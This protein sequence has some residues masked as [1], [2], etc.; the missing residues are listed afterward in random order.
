MKQQSEW[1][2]LDSQVDLLQ[3]WIIFFLFLPNISWKWLINPIYDKS[4]LRHTGFYFHR[5]TCIWKCQEGTNDHMSMVVLQQFNN[6]KK[7]LKTGDQTRECLLLKRGNVKK[8]GPFYV[9]WLVFP[10]NKHSLIWSLSQVQN[11][12]PPLTAAPGGLENLR[13]V[14][15]ICSVFLLHLSSECCSLCIRSMFAVHVFVWHS[16]NALGRCSVFAIVD[17]SGLMLE[18]QGKPIRSSIGRVAIAI[19]AC[20]SEWALS[21]LIRKAEAK[22]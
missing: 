22:Y 12:A 1:E 4:E 19:S 6:K 2:W 17:W 14:D 15:S 3:I 20:H 9:P 18:Y 10:L 7:S 13:R 11:Q 21:T 5:V 8:K 16:G